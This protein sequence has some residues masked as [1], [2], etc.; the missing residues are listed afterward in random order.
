[1]Q[2]VVGIVLVACALVLPW[3]AGQETLLLITAGAGGAALIVA[4]VFGVGRRMMVGAAC[5]L[6]AAWM[7]FG[8]AGPGVPEVVR[9]L[10]AAIPL[11]AAA[12]HVRG[13][14]RT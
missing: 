11:L 10:V 7:L 9:G 5:V 1:V 3:L 14:G 6:L 12:E 2:R 13:L 8:P 4:F